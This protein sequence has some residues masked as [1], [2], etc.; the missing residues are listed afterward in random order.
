LIKP[1]GEHF[2]QIYHVIDELS[3]ASYVVELYRDSYY[4]TLPPRLG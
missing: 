3:Q 1:G 4:L 2:E